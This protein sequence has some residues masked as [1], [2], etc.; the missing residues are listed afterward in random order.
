MMCEIEKLDHTNAAVR[1]EI[2]AFLA[3]S[4]RHA[5]FI[6]GNLRMNFPQSHLFVASNLGRWLGIAGYYSIPKSIIPFSEDAGVVRALVRYAA[7]VHGPIEY[8]NGIDYAAGPAYEELLKMGYQP[9]GNPHQVFM[10]MT[11]LPSRQRHEASARPLEDRDKYEIAHLLRCLSGTWNENRPLTDGEVE[12]IGMNPLRIV[13]EDG[14]R[15]VATA[16][17]NGLGIRCYQILGVATHPGFRRLG[18]ARAAVAFLMRRM[19]ELGGRQAVL[20]TGCEN[21]AAQ[22]CYQRLGFDITGN[23]YVGKLKRL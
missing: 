15:I 4:E 18:Y 13:V 1:K 3:G 14:N 17:T 20:F 12:S 19:A 11:G 8:V 9:A 10:E 6:L 5:L 16:C 7:S 22:Q 23:Y 2:F 21:T